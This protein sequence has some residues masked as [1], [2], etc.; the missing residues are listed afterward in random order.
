MILVRFYLKGLAA[1][2]AGVKDEVEIITVPGILPWGPPIVPD[3]NYYLDPNNWQRWDCDEFSIFYDDFDR[4][5]WLDED[6]KCPAIANPGQ[7]DVGGITIAPPDGIGDACQCGDVNNSG[8]VNATDGL[9]IN[10]ASLNIGVFSV[11]NGATVSKTNAPFFLHG[12][13]DVNASLACT[14]TDG[15]IVNRVSLGLDPPSSI[16]NACAGEVLP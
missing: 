5:S 8:H 4:D 6:D 13:C 14:S 1:N 2:A 10:Q 16:V 11:T 7:Q 3:P 15:L 9:I 12:K